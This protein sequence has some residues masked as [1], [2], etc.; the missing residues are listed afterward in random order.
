MNIIYIVGILT[1]LGLTIVVAK[2]FD[3]EGVILPHD[4][5]DQ[6]IWLVHIKPAAS[7]VNA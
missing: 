3:K 1:E 6:R 7:R 2:L 5:P 4:L